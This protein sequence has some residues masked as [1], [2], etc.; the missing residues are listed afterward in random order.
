M[1]G[2]L[3]RRTAQRVGSARYAATSCA[4]A[5]LALGA[6]PAIAR[7][8]VA[9]ASAG[10]A[11]RPFLDLRAAATQRPR[12]L[13]ARAARSRDRL[14][15]SLGRSGVLDIEPSTGTP[16]VVARLDGLLTRPSGAA[17]ARIVLRYVRAH[18]ALFGLDRRG[19]RTLHAS[20]RYTD[21]AGITHLAWRQSYRGLAAFDNG[22]EA[23]VA[24]DGRLINVRGAPAPTLAPR[25]LVPR[26]GRVDARRRARGDALGPAR[27]SGPAAA[28]V[29]ASLPRRVLFALAPGD[30]RLAWEVR[31]AVPGGERYEQL[32]DA[33]SGAVLRRAAGRREA[34]ALAWPYAPNVGALGVPTALSAFGQ[35]AVTIATNSSAALDGPNAH[36]YADANDDNVAQ[37][38]EETPASAGSDWSY[39]F[40]PAPANVPANLACA[41]VFPV[42]SLRPN[43]GND[44]KTNRN[45]TATQAYWFVN[46]F[47]DYLKNDPGI[48]FDAASGNFE[49][50]GGDA[51]NVE[52][53]DGAATYAPSASTSIPD[54]VHLNNASMLT[55]RDGNPPRM[56]LSVFARSGW[57]DVNASDDAT[58]VYHEYAHGLSDRLVTDPTGAGA[59]DGRQ[60][61]A[62]A[63]GWSDWYAMDYLEAQGLERADTATPGEINVGVY[64]AGGPN[65]VRTE[66]L[67]CPVGSGAPQC[68]GT[69]GAGAG[70]YTFGDLSKIS[71]VGGV[72]DVHADGELWAQTLWDLRRRMIA[73]H[74]APGPATGIAI[75]RK[76]VTEGM[77]L[78]PPQPSMLDVRNAIVQADQVVNGGANRAA[79]WAV[80]A[81]RGMGFFASALDG[82]DPGPAEDFSVPPGGPTGTLRGRVLDQDTGTPVAGV[83]VEL[84]AHASG[85]PGDFAATTDAGGA[86][87]LP[88]IPPGT[89]PN[90]LVLGAGYDPVLQASL[91]VP[92]AE[93]VADFQV[94]RNW[95][96]A[97]VGTKLAG[98]TGPDLTPFGCGPERVRDQRQYTG[99]ATTSPS[100]PDAPGAKSLTFE[101]PQALDTSSFAIDPAAIC[102]DDD[103]ASTGSY[104]VWTSADGVKFKLVL[105][106]PLFPVNNH[107]LNPLTP[108]PIPTGVRF[109]K[110]VLESPQSASPTTS[111]YRF[112]DVAEFAIYGQPTRP[113]TPITPTGIPPQG[114]KRDT[115]PPTLGAPRTSGALTLAVLGRGLAIKSSC[116]ERCTL[117]ASISISRATAKRV[118]LRTRRARLVIGSGTA[119]VA[120]AGAGTV[121]V[122]ISAKTRA[123]L[124]RLRSFKALV[125]LTAVDAGGNAAKAKTATLTIKR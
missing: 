76:L 83:R 72:S 36:V 96:T 29:R 117:R 81:A 87:S 45:Q 30:V 13:G 60:S 68:P 62:M 17:P 118:K 20:R 51:V 107:T 103:S 19:L 104:S 70:G 53:L 115:T 110:L 95:A 2:G 44:W 25:S 49:A 85:F 108:D 57:P 48:G 59:L 1:L 24:P 14:A 86:F 27:A 93:I 39:A 73:D 15:A 12:A 102:G 52:V 88:G 119:K 69:G 4:I 101:L 43:V 41:V 90:L 11:A 38:T 3:R 121:S 97:A 122:K 113:V 99:W 120:A 23:S 54:R 31:T 112:M 109:V 46:N 91:T 34:S 63:E 37:P 33:R 47:H 78:A 28:R 105:H 40:T 65:R 75:T 64:V 98:L 5:M 32:I 116:S 58:V 50:A 80:F 111:G 89:Y 79:I 35:V 71:T 125:T 114:A 56:R 61:A 74:P 55:S 18:A 9:P 77:R 21:V 84:A 124:R 16:R 82:D 10:A 7:A 106:G 67:D 42:C 8:P 22:L 92:A 66:G 100:N 123:K 26:I 94:R 6:A